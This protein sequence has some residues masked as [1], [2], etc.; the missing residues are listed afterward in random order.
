MKKTSLTL[1]ALSLLLTVSC[2][3]QTY[4]VKTEPQR[5]IASLALDSETLEV[6][7]LA[8]KGGIS[9]LQLKEMINTYIEA[10]MVSQDLLSKFDQELEEG[11]TQILSSKTYLKLLAMKPMVEQLK[12]NLSHHYV[13]L[14]ATHLIQPKSAGLIDEFHEYLAKLS[15]PRN[16]VT[17]YAMVDLAEM[18]HEIHKKTSFTHEHEWK[19]DLLSN[20][21]VLIQNAREIPIRNVGYFKERFKIDKYLREVLS[22]FEK[23]KVANENLKIFPSTTSAGNITGN[24]FPLNTWAMTFDDGPHQTRTPAMLEVLA[25]HNVKGTFFEL[26]KNVNAMKELSLKVK[27]AGHEMANHSFTHAQLTKVTDAALKY[28]IVDS[29][30]VLTQVWGEPPKFFRTPY[31]AGTNVEKI[32]KVIADQKMIHVFWNVDTL[33]WQDKNPVT[34]VERARKQIDV[35]KK[36]VILFHDIHDQSVK[37]TD[38]LLKEM[39]AKGIRFTT[40]SEIV[41]ELN[42]KP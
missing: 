11:N 4:Q 18:V 7:Q 21:D 26:A 1:S 25:K 39:T 5:K 19:N 31:G 17:R 22:S 42:K 30:Q 35:L 23:V 28:E 6:V 32:R 33:D 9:F 37:A 29:T 24:G 12:E 40:M 15:A 41:D 8:Q 10:R 16:V 14:V 27:A 3:T 20:R 2:S 13:A 38:L 34:I 36:G